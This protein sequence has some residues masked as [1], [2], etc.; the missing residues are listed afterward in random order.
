MPRDT[1]LEEIID[2]LW[3]HPENGEW[4]PKTCVIPGKSFREWM[5]SSDIE[6]LG[7]TYHM[8]SDHRFRVEPQL[9]LDEYL[10]FVRRYY[11]RCFI[12]NPDGEWADSRWSAGSDLVNVLAFHWNNAEVP[13][14]VM[15]DWKTW[16]AD[17]YKRGSEE[18]RKCIIQATLEH[19]LEQG[20]FRKFFADWVKDPDLRKAYE[21][22]LEWYVG[23]GRTPL[24][25]SPD[26]RSLVRSQPQKSRLRKR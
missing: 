2:T 21:E 9:S 12:E 3:V 25:K 4:T 17:I 20:A 26:V 8:L 1:T 22:G 13:K 6:A 18:V 19:L 24:G 15:E 10:E 7:F 11:G 23:G 5:L 14:S 16:L